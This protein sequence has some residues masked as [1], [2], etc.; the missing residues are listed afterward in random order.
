MQDLSRRYSADPA[1]LRVYD[2]IDN[3]FEP[4][5]GTRFTLGLDFAGGVLGGD[6]YFY[7]PEATYSFFRPVSVSALRTVF[8][9]NVEGG[10]VHPFGDHEPDPLGALL[11]RRR[12][13]RSAASAFRGSIVPAQAERRRRVPDAVG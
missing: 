9:F 4:T 1:V 13:H 8:A 3:R 7:R 6:T 2:S 5:R 12:E 10:Y 11:P